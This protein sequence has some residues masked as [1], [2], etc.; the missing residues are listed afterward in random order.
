MDFSGEPR[1]FSIFKMY[2]KGID[3]AMFVFDMTDYDSIIHYED[4]IKR[5]Y[6]N[7]P[8][9]LPMIIVGMKSDL[10]QDKTLLENS[11]HIQ[12]LEGSGL[13]F[14]CSAKTGEN[15]KSVFKTIVEKIYEKRKKETISTILDGINNVH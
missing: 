2:C 8:E 1:F 6:E 7:V 13:Y 3:G 14:Q 5:I 15:V 4:W 11:Q 9:D 10:I 12:E